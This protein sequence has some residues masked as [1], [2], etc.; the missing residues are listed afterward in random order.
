MVLLL[1]LRQA[2]CHPF[3][4][5]D[6]A[7]T[8]PDLS[9]IDGS[10]LEGMIKVAK[11]LRP[12][13]V[14]RIIEAVPHGFECPICYDASENPRIISP[15]GH[16]TCSECLSRLMDNASVQA[17]AEGNHDGS[18][19]AKCPECRAVLTKAITDL[20]CFR[21]VHMPEMI[22]AEDAEDANLM[23][24]LVAADES[25]S[26]SDTSDESDSDLDDFVVSDGHETSDGGEDSGD[27]SM[28][29]LDWKRELAKKKL[30]GAQK[31]AKE[32]SGSEYEEADEQD[33]SK[34]KSNSE[35]QGKDKA[36]TITRTRSKS[37]AKSKSLK[38][39]KGKGKRKAKSAEKK[40]R[41]KEKETKTLGRL[42]A[43]SS[44]NK[45]SKKK[46]MKYLKKTW[47]TSGKIEKCV[48][49]LRSIREAD[50]TEKTII[51][52]QWTSLLDLLEVPVSA[53]KWRFERYGTSHSFLSAMIIADSCHLDGSMS[54]SARNDAVINFTDNPR[55]NI[56]L[57]SL[58]AGNSGLNLTSASQVV[59]VSFSTHQ[60]RLICVIGYSRSFLESVY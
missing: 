5:R 15:C 40:K 19:Q 49:I 34:L 31:D 27:E 44:R 58:K 6:F 32:D 12:E 24:I 17:L 41:P 16:D 29:E 52:S 56:M 36:K 50:R 54:A 55:C 3:L 60:I 4:T 30:A 38:D 37:E 10:T 18:G 14:E 1:R 59:S 26:D 42:K 43:E 21:K 8:G 57:V 39:A 25:D 22:A 2:C 7:E 46:Y 9:N 33:T 51:F 35:G 13:V 45:E 48:E 20:V 53:Q 28:E 11:D 47:E 23:D